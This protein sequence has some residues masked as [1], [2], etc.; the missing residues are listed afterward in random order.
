MYITLTITQFLDSSTIY[1]SKIENILETGW[2]VQKPSS[3]MEIM[4]KQTMGSS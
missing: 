1:Y 4:G 2:T 3:I